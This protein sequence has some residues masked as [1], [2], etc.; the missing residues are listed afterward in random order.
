MI[1]RI[2]LERTLLR[3]NNFITAKALAHLWSMSSFTNRAELMVK[4]RIQLLYAPY[5]FYKSEKLCLD[6]AFKLF[7]VECLDMKLF[8]Y[9][10]FGK[11]DDKQYPIN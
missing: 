1:I 10:G 3:D 8:I 9:Q 6:T 11:C 7:N 2:R 5:M 4:K